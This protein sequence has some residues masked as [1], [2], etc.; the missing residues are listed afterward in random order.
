MD[1]VYERESSVEESCQVMMQHIEQLTPLGI[2]H[3]T[4]VDIDT[5]LKITLWESWSLLV[6]RDNQSARGH[7]SKLVLILNHE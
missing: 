1:G 6:G 2:V 5:V 4:A 3:C 7:F